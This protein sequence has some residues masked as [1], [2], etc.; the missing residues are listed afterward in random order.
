[1]S[2]T[3]KGSTGAACESYHKAL[4]ISKTVYGDESEEACYALIQHAEALSAIGR[5]TAASN[6]LEFAALIL[7]KLENSSYDHRST[8]RKTQAQK[9]AISLKLNKVYLQLTNLYFSMG[10]KVE[11]A[12]RLVE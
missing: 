10:T 8:K 7:G 6:Q 9:D 11:E 5:D 3:R 12:Q 1:M 4:N 2:L